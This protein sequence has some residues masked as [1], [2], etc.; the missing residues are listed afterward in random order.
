MSVDSGLQ[1]RGLRKRYSNGVEALRGVDLSVGPGMYGLLGPNGAGKSSL[2]R[3]LATLQQ[4]DAGSI[5]LDGVDVLV[6]ADHLRRRLGY[7]PQQLG[8]YPGVSARDLLD[9]FAWL[10]GRTDSRQRREEIEGLLDKVNLRQAAHRA[11]ATYSGGMLRRFGIAMALVGSPRL[12][13]V[14]EP[15]AGLDPAERNRF[16]RV[17][18]DVAAESIV[19]LST[20][21]VEDVENLCS[22]LA[23][24]AGGQIIVE[25]SPA[26][27][28]GAEQGRL[29]E[30]SFDRGEALPDALHVAASP[31]GSRVIV[32]GARPAD[33][34]FV[35]HAPRLEDI[36]YL[37]L[38]Q[39][40]EA[41]DA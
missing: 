16:H 38:A 35:P 27:L 19:L 8:A 20:H 12:L 9:R 22:R 33:P 28:L 6:D 23:V 14:D 40:G 24:L 21:I 15:T 29:W 3:T 10:K 41:V 37:A 5:H 13:I 34:R 17:L 25:G 2:M 30:A 4:P 36:Y 7:L 1:V 26:Q 18:A 32:H 31:Q 11:L 39:A